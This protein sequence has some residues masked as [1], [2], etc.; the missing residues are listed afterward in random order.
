MQ[1]KK[2]ADLIIEAKGEKPGQRFH[3]AS[4]ATGPAGISSS[5]IGRSDFNPQDP[6]PIKGHIADTKAKSVRDTEKILRNAFRVIKGNATFRDRLNALLST[7]AKKRKQIRADQEKVLSDYPGQIDKY[8]GEKTRLEKIIQAIGPDDDRTKAFTKDLEATEEKL[9]EYSE[10]LENV[11]QQALNIIGINEDNSTDYQDQIINLVQ[12]T[13]DEEYDKLLAEMSDRE[14]AEIKLRS[15]DELEP[16]LLDDDQLDKDEH[17]L[18]LLNVLQSKDPDENPL[19]KFFT[20]ANQKY[21]EAKLSDAH[22]KGVSRNTQNVSV[23]MLYNRLPTS[24]FIYFYNASKE[25]LPVRKITGKRRKQMK[26]TSPILGILD[27]IKSEEDFVK[28]RY[29]LKD[30]AGELDIDAGRMNAVL[31]VIDGPYKK[32][33]TTAV[34]KIRGMLK[35]I[36]QEST[37]LEMLALEILSNHNAD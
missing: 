7:F 25:D 14:K 10:E 16:E 6:V 9:E 5:P 21:E 31:G 22:F 1:F 37:T 20:L 34:Q 2:L 4:Q 29:E 23:E 35:G 32:R 12:Y 8:F 11:R 17:R 15:L 27:G 24:N 36:L 13:S 18:E 19:I 28:Q 26:A 3:G 33:G 30:L